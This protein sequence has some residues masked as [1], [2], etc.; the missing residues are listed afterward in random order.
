MSLELTP[1]AGMLSETGTERGR[2]GPC[3][4]SSCLAVSPAQGSGTDEAAA[5]PE[6]RRARTRRGPGPRPG[7]TRRRT[8]RLR[9]MMLAAER[10]ADG[11]PAADDQDCGGY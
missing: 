9:S 6:S 11:G 7:G 10:Y 4:A 8:G 2:V 3:A 1:M 5:P